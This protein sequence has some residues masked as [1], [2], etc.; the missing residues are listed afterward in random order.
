M[1]YQIRWSPEA[2]EDIEEIATYIHKDSPIYAQKV[3]EELIRRLAAP[4]AVPAS[5]AAGTRA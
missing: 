3:V 4:D 2:V 5:R 1:D